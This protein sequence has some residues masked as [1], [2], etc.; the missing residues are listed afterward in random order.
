MIFNPYPVRVSVIQHRMPAATP[1]F[2][3]VRD[4]KTAAV[5]L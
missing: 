1:K 4:W 2:S 3:A 5:L